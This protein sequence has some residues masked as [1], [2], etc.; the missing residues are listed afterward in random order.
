M[1]AQRH[2]GPSL[3]R[4]TPRRVTILH[5]DSD[6]DLIAQTTSQP[7]Q[8]VLPA[9]QHPLEPWRRAEADSGSGPLPLLTGRLVGLRG[10]PGV[11]Q[12]LAELVLGEHFVCL[13][14]LKGARASDRDAHGGGAD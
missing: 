4:T 2:L 9:R 1:R 3:S 5:Y 6:D 8:C 13:Q 12:Y 10:V 7:A 11:R 14:V